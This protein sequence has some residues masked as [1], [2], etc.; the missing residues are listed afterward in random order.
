MRRLPERLWSQC[1]R[2]LASLIGVTNSID[3]VLCVI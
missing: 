3:E 2:K 1:G